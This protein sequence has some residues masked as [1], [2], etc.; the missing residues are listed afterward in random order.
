M[1]EGEL[2]LDESGRILGLRTRMLHDAGAYMTWGIVC[3]WI[4]CTT[5]PGPY[6]V[7]AY[8]M[9][10]QVVMTNKPPVTPVRGAGRP[11]AA[12]FMERMMD[13]AAQA[14]GLERD[15]IRRRNYIQPEQMPYAVGLIFRYGQP[16]EY[17]TGDYPRCHAMA[18]EAADFA[19]FKERRRR[20]RAEG[21]HLGIGTS[22]YIEATGLGPYEGVSVH[23][24]RNGEVVVHTGAAPQGQ[25][26]QTMIAQ[27]VADSLGVHFDDITVKVSDTVTVPRGVGTFA[28]RITP[29]ATPAASIAAGKVREKVLKVAAHLLEAAEADLEVTLGRVHVRG[30]EEHGKS[31]AEIASF[32]NHLPGFA[33]PAGLDPVLEDTTYF[34]PARAT[35]PCGSHVAEVEVDI[36][37]GG[38]RIVRYASAHDCG[39]I[40]NP[41]SVEAQVMGGVAHGIGNALFEWMRYDENAQPLTVNFGEYL[42]PSA[43]EVPNVDQVHMESPTPI[44][45]LGAK[46][47]GEGGTIPATAAVVSAIEDALEPFGVRIDDVPV[48]P[49]RLLELIEAGRKD[50]A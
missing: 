46:G 28:S 7:P 14:V 10:C 29:N 3:P 22:S 4:S 19:G 44:N 25:G 41:V 42:L 50:T 34:A 2:A 5:V 13:R 20:A 43:P 37:T 6:V 26:H 23:L 9:R 45:P 38:V 11:Q 33:V 32:A 17:D 8:E 27:V 47:A 24:Q 35:Y 15:E 40:I 48:T 1:W 49:D 16:V 21:R 30:V 18:L 36:G 31:F 39:T 12:Y